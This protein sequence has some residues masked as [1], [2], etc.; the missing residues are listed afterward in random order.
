MCPIPD[1]FISPSA[2]CLRSIP[3][4]TIIDHL[5][6][7]DMKL[8]AFFTATATS[9]LLSSWTTTPFIS[10]AATKVPP[11]IT[12]EYIVTENNTWS[13]YSPCAGEEIE[14]TETDYFRIIWVINN[15]RNNSVITIRREGKGIGLTTG[16]EY[17]LRGHYTD[18]PEASL[19][20]QN[21]Q[22]TYIF[23]DNYSLVSPGSANNIS[24]RSKY[25]FVLSPKSEVIID[26][27]SSETY[28]R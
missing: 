22:F 3:E 6:L 19:P 9:L 14:V 23:V 26:K 17:I 16:T 8:L 20:S 27:Y 18:A 15:N 1:A 24:V 7:K 21:D 5:K 13:F 2:D 25:R 4:K 11:E 12:K 28:C 10:L